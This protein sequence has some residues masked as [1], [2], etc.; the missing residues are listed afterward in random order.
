ME[1][2][3][4]L[5]NTHI[6]FY[7]DSVNTKISPLG[8]D[9]KI[10][11]FHFEEAISYPY[12]G[13]LVVRAKTFLDFDSLDLKCLIA[14]IDYAIADKAKADAKATRFV[15][16]L[17]KSIQSL[18]EF[19]VIENNQDITYYQYQITLVSP[20]ERLKNYHCRNFYKGLKVHEIIKKLL[21]PNDSVHLPLISD[22][23]IDVSKLSDIAELDT[24]ALLIQ[25]NDESYYDFFNRLLIA[26]G[27]NYILKFDKDG[28]KI[29]F[30]R[31]QDYCNDQENKVLPIGSQ[32]KNAFECAKD[33]QSVSDLTKFAYL[34]G[35]NYSRNYV[36]TDK[37]EEVVKAVRHSFLSIETTGNDFNFLKNKQIDE[38][39]NNIKTRLNLSRTLVASSTFRDIRVS[40]GCHLNIIHSDN[41]VP[42]ILKSLITDISV[43]SKDPIR[44]KFEGLSLKGLHTDTKLGCL[45][46]SGIAPE[47]SINSASGRGDLDIVE[48]VVCGKNGSITEGEKSLDVDDDRGINNDKFYAKIDN[49]DVK[50]VHSLKT[51]SACYTNKMVQGQPILVLKKNGTYY[52]YSTKAQSLDISN[53]SSLKDVDDNSE[54][55][56]KGPNNGLIHY[57]EYNSG[58]EYILSLLMN[59]A[60]AV[61][62][63]IRMAALD[64]SDT[65][66]H[67]EK[68]LENING[69]EAGK[70]ATTIAAYK[71]AKS[72]LRAKLKQLKQDCD[73]GSFKDIEKELPTKAIVLTD[74]VKA[75]TS[76]AAET[77]ELQKL[78]DKYNSAFENLNDLATKIN[79]D[80]RLQ[81]LEKMRQKTAVPSV[82]EQVIAE[83]PE[84]NPDA[85]G[86][87]ESESNRRE[88]AL[89]RKTLETLREGYKAREYVRS[90]LGIENS[91]EI[92]VQSSG[93]DVIISGDNIKLIGSSSITLSAPTVTMEGRSSV[94]S[95]VGL[96]KVTVQPD[97]TSI[98]APAAYNGFI[99]KKAGQASD[100]MSSSLAVK[101]Y[102]GIEASA[103]NVSLSATNALSLGDCLGGGISLGFGAVALKGSTVSI[104]T[105][106]KFNQGLAL[107]SMTQS[108][109]MD[110]AASLAGGSDNG[111]AYPS[112]QTAF[113]LPYSI[114]GDVA[115]FLEVKGGVQEARANL[116]QP[117]AG[118][119]RHMLRFNYVQK[120][121]ACIF[122]TL[123]RIYEVLKLIETSMS[124]HASK[125]LS[126]REKANANIKQV[127][128]D[129]YD[130]SLYDYGEYTTN[131]YI[132]PFKNS[133]HASRLDH[134][135]MY[136][137]HLKFLNGMIAAGATCV[138][139]NLELGSPFGAS[140][141]E[142]STNCITTTTQR[143]EH[144]MGNVL[145][146]IAP[147]AGV[148]GD[149][150]NS[151]L[152]EVSSADPDSEVSIG[153]NNF[154]GSKFDAN[155]DP[156]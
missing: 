74:L 44:L 61:D 129:D 50:L 107:A 63:A 145:Y 96:S 58:K 67:D 94:V 95:S 80:C 109:V 15:W 105:T 100:K 102:A 25:P 28:V 156:V 140:S 111:H 1:I 46:P 117:P 83:H 24:C 146:A 27:I 131:E 154:D 35:E 149:D 127:G 69:G 49:G 13:M 17:V 36:A 33:P 142:L 108:L 98:Y 115:E 16:T 147:A 153:L 39:E 10:S 155:G 106:G 130:D 87:S 48:A 7:K 8:D 70:V 133:I 66:I 121:I 22:G 31:D 57:S 73:A 65:S 51:S 18:P 55:I 42:Y 128:V 37:T 71:E 132:N 148:N 9:C 99:P 62:K 32:R 52:L 110:I 26:Y 89:K 54:Q 64:Q 92:R 118:V 151:A 136:I 20:L 43:D 76:D 12:T 139:S 2:Y 141:I 75:S 103:F 23:N 125:K 14:K 41:R 40:P 135:R 91:G 53:A 3:K 101:G 38:I 143:D 90:C 138:R 81:Y 85:E 4:I 93:S 68:Y 19:H 78:V 21:V 47:I 59:N 60:D 137:Q 126:N 45:M 124:L 56:W 86:I 30:S 122:Y 150:P 34:T 97:G 123:D 84:L 6:S 134:V 119:S 88:E 5:E 144:K 82:K 72:A 112:V 113:G 11:S 120:I 77:N 114:I 104:S 29:I 152:S 116:K 79:D